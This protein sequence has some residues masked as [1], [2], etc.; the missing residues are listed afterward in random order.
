MNFE[1]IV[2]FDRSDMFDD[3]PYTNDTFD[4]QGRPSELMNI[5]ISL[6]LFHYN[7]VDLID[8]SCYIY[9]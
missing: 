3:Y 2:M 4:R 6:A 8:M 1:V 5:H 7:F 9:V